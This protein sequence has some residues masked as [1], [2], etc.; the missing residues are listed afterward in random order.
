L[1]EILKIDPN[2]AQKGSEFYKMTKKISG[3]P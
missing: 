2:Y 3:R 1:D